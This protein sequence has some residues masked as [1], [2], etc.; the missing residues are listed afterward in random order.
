[1]NNIRQIKIKSQN[2][3][4]QV[5]ILAWSTPKWEIKY[6]YSQGKSKIRNP[7]GHLFGHLFAI[8]TLSRSS[9][10][11][12]VLWFW[13]QLHNTKLNINNLFTFKGHATC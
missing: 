5:Y 6:T 13:Y 8:G 9:R 12:L 11:V 4:G 10:A 1:M 7:N 2:L 3:I